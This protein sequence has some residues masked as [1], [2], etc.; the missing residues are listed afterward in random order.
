MHAELGRDDRRLQVLKDS[1]D[2]GIPVLLV[3]EIT[4]GP[5]VPVSPILRARGYPHFLVVT[6]YDV[7]RK[8]VFCLGLDTSTVALSYRRLASWWKRTDYAFLRV[9]PSE[10]VL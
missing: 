3:V 7:S 10:E 6:G 4:A 1:I 2:E 9:F 5:D 8:R